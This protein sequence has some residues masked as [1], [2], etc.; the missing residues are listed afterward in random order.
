M[1]LCCWSH[2]L[3]VYDVT[4]SFWL[5]CLKISDLLANWCVN[6]IK[7]FISENTIVP[8]QP[9][10]RSMRLP[11]LWSQPWW[12]H[13]HSGT[14]WRIQK[15]ETGDDWVVFQS[16]EQHNRLVLCYKIFL[17]ISSALNIIIFMELN[18]HN[19]KIKNDTF[20]CRNVWG[21]NA[22]PITLKNCFF[23]LLKLSIIHIPPRCS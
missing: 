12:R 23:Q 7:I 2:T 15:P 5:F 1:S 19:N 3:T 10:D 9:R 11:V 4:L 22:F 18:M 20:M 14:A 8:H 6:T 21:L 16:V 17:E 13:R